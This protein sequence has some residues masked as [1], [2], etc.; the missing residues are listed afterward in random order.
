LHILQKHLQLLQ[1]EEYLILIGFIIGGILGRVLLQGIPSAE[2]ITLFAVLAGSL[3][4][5]KKGAA[6]GASSWYLSNFFM[7]GGQ[8]PWTLIHMFNGASAGF[9]GS[10]VKNKSNY[11]KTASIMLIATLIFEITMNISSGLFLGI[12]ILTSFIT[13]LPFMFTHI[14]SNLGFSLII[15]KARKTILDTGKLSEISICKGY[16]Q[17]FKHFRK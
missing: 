2:P 3:F 1:L 6:V 7:F 11:I 15:P 4:G 16:I 5:W 9:L 13:A 10:L 17:N 8:G 14:V 12:G